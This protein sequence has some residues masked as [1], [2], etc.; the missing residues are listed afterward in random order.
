MDFGEQSQSRDAQRHQLLRKLVTLR[1]QLQAAVSAAAAVG[2]VDR[3]RR[4]PDSDAW[5]TL[6]SKCLRLLDLVA[7]GSEAATAAVAAAEAGG[8]A[9]PA[10]QMGEM[11]SSAARSNR[12][13][14]APIDVHNPYKRIRDPTAPVRPSPYTISG[15]FG[16]G[17]STLY[18]KYDP[19]EQ[20]GFAAPGAVAPRSLHGGI[21]RV[22]VPTPSKPSTPAAAP[23]VSPAATKAGGKAA[24]ASALGS[25]GMAL[26]ASLREA[27]LKRAPVLPSGSHLRDVAPMPSSVLANY[28]GLEIS[29][30]WG[31][32]DNTAEIPQVCE[33]RHLLTFRRHN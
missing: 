23:S 24:E 11:R 33:E 12:V 3:P 20:L 15:I 27:L 26:P 7:S 10:A 1:A 17:R 32:V 18:T 31:P 29:N 21:P 30:H 16:D 19:S 9:G 28:R 14:D 2:A 13:G 8:S 5:K 22:E 25:S 4:P 6:P